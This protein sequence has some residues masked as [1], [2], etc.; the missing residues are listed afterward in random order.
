MNHSLPVLDGYV[1]PPSR[2]RCFFVRGK[3]IKECPPPFS[4]LSLYRV[5]FNSAQ[6]KEKGLLVAPGW[7]RCL[8]P[9]LNNRCFFEER[10]PLTRIRDF[11]TNRNDKERDFSKL[12]QLYS[13]LWNNW[14]DGTRF[15]FSQ[16][17]LLFLP[18]SSVPSL[19]LLLEFLRYWTELKS[20]WICSA[21]VS[22]H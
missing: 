3:P 2:D 20:A 22:L 12:K 14:E 16:H 9:H 10:A 5:E 17:R 19:L 15:K 4:H 11:C 13:T 1:M 21:V 6:G 8:S 18:L 7:N